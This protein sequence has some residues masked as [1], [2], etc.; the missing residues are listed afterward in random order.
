MS[1]P[2]HEKSVGV[3]SIELFFDLVFVFVITQ[4]TQLVEHAHRPMD[5]L[6]VLLVLVA[7]LW[8]SYFDREDRRAADALVAAAPEERSRMGLFGYWY[9][10]LALI[11]G[12][13]LIAAGIRQLLERG[14]KPAIPGWGCSQAAWPSSC[15]GT[16][17][18]DG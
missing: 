18:S 13:I 6:R 14:G 9:A 11:A 8:W 2:V 3:S 10:H 15:S 12:I 17:S 1:A 4:V 16:F 7:S 5:F